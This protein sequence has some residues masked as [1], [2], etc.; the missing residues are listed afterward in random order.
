MNNIT[1]PIQIV[2]YCRPYVCMFSNQYWHIN[3][4]F[5]KIGRIAIKQNGIFYQQGYNRRTV[6]NPDLPTFNW[7]WYDRKSLSWWE[8]QYLVSNKIYTD[9]KQVVEEETNRYSFKRDFELIVVLSSK[10]S[11]E[12][13]KKMNIVDYEGVVNILAAQRITQRLMSKYS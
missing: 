7:D 3:D 9:L 5:G 8:F 6:P 1:L 11:N 2:S 13:I 12:E 4:D 10:F